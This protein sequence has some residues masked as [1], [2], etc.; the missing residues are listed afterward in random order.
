MP[1]LRKIWSRK[2]AFARQFSMGKKNPKLRK[3]F[4]LFHKQYFQ[5]PF[6][7]HPFNKVLPFVRQ[8][9]LFL[10][11]NINRAFLHGL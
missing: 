7:V 8:K 5:Q 6:G 11:K 4:A 3:S 10:N 1:F 2:K 9:R